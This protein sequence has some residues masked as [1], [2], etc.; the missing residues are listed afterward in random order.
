MAWESLNKAAIESL[1]AR[2][3]RECSEAKRQLFERVRIAPVKWVQSPWGEEGGGFWAVAVLNDRVLWYNDIE[4]GFNVSR[5]TDLGTIP[6]DEYWCNQDT[7]DWA[8]GH[9]E[10]GPGAR[11]GPPEPLH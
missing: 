4:E 3:L 9:L 11:L 2:D 7:L 1:V 8:L 6:S 10:N 5:F